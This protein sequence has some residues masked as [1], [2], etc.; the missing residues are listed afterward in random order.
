MQP[1]GPEGRS[2]LVTNNFYV[3]TRWNR[4]SYFAIAVGMLA[5]TLGSR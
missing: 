3:L 5:D 2:F 1:D 4:S